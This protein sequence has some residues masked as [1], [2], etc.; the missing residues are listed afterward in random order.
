MKVVDSS[1]MR[2]IDERT[3]KEYGLPGQV[4]MERA[5]LSVVRR[6][7]ELFPKKQKPI[8]LAGGGNNGGDGLVIARLLK[9][10]GW[11]VKVHFLST[12]QKASPDCKT[13]LETAKKFGVAM[14]NTPPARA[15]FHAAIVVDA[16]LGTGLSK[17]VTGK[18]SEVVEDINRYGEQIVAVDIPTGISSDDGQVMGAA[19][20]AGY[21]VTFGLPK[22]GHIL[23]PGAEYAGRLFVEEI[24]FPRELLTGDDL[25]CELIEK[26]H[27]AALIPERPVFSHKQTF[28]HVL[29]LAGSRGKTGAAL[30]CAKAVL[31]T[32]AG[33]V[34][35]GIPEETAAVFQ[36][37]VTDEMTLPLPSNAGSL[38]GQALERIFSFIHERADVV[39]AGPGLGVTADTQSLV[40]DIVRACPAPMVLDADALNSLNGDISPLAQ[41]KAPI[42]ITP[43]PGEMGRLVGIKTA[44]IEKDRIRA[45]V[46][47][48]SET[49][50]YVILKGARTVIAS[51]EGKSFIN[52]TGTSGMAK[53]GTG[54]VLTGMVAGFLAQGLLPLDAALLGVYV[55][56]LA[57]EL[58]AA[59]RGLHSMLA[60]DMHDTIGDAIHH[61]KDGHHLSDG[62]DPC[63]GGE[64]FV[65]VP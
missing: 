31:R 4:L 14:I 21:T 54:D 49:G 46:S 7:K 33:L 6:I 53:A 17:D 34:T 3:I 12:P 36:S 39:A 55:H 61:L 11:N 65:P 60:S 50:A 52:T 62:Q 64:F 58:A 40:P 29:A 2:A 5:G 57:G 13:Q 45:A 26:G 32:G 8:I 23:A 20:R 41:S 63:N 28:G 51:P 44:D 27:A 42:I 1:Q 56:G 30:L 9:N 22:R 24:G 48:S 25:L 16:I 18:F 10:D 19:V 15:D 38:S 59:R 47:L 43:H 37:M 35:M